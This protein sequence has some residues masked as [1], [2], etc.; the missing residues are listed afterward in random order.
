MILK[1]LYLHIGVLGLPTDYTYTFKKRSRFICNWLD[2]E[3]LKPLKSQCNEFD[4]IVVMLCSTP[5]PS[6]YVNTSKVAC[7]E[8]P[9]DRYRIDASMGIAFTELQIA[10]LKSGIEKCA[11]TLAIPKS[12]LFRGLEVFV[13]QGMKNEWLHKNRTFKQHD[14]TAALSCKMTQEVFSLRLCV[15]RHKTT[16]FDE[17]ILETETDEVVFNHKFKDIIIDNDNLVVTARIGSPLWT[18]PLVELVAAT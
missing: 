11:E 4:R 6:A 3:V 1:S 15:L 12:D 13:E 18:K 14:L 2:R 5:N 8:I 16:V 7:V 9:F 17:V 10:M